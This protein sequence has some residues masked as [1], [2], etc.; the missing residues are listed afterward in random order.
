MTAIL[1]TVPHGNRK[2]DKVA[3]KMMECLSR[4]L[5][6]VVSLTNSK[7][8]KE[9]DMNR[10]ESR[11]SS[12]R[13]EVRSHLQRKRGYLLDV[14]SSPTLGD[15]EIEFLTFP[16]VTQNKLVDEMVDVISKWN[17]VVGKVPSAKVDDISLEAWE[18]GWMPFLLETYE[19]LSDKRLD[20]IAGVIALAIRKTLR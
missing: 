11:T 12:F 6:R 1:V 5:P 4:Y 15:R 7:L 19:G 8:R 9:I 16:Y 2:D 13:R 14:H 18:Y 17:V 3:V 20:E 10:P